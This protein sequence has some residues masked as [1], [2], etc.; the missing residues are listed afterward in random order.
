MNVASVV[1]S[2]TQISSSLVRGRVI[3]RSGMGMNYFLFF[4]STLL[5][6][7]VAIS[8]VLIRIF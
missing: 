6:C 4:S 2:D 5:V 3:F 8:I 7:I 1:C